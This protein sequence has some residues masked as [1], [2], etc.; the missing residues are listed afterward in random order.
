ME[1]NPARTLRRAARSD[2]EL[3]WVRGKELFDRLAG[4]QGDCRD[5]GW[6]ASCQPQKSGPGWC[7]PSDNAVQAV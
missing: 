2:R 6:T 5:P 4:A 1:R 3:I 7:A